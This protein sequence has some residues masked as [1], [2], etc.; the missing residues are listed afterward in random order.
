M[1]TSPPSVSTPVISYE[2]LCSSSYDKMTKNSLT[3]LSTS[4]TS[5]CAT[6]N[7]LSLDTN[8]TFYI[9]SNAFV[10]NEVSN[11]LKHHT[12]FIQHKTVLD[13]LQN[14]CGQV[15]SVYSSSKLTHADI[16][17]QNKCVGKN[18]PVDSNCFES[19][20]SQISNEGISLNCPSIEDLVGS[21]SPSSRSHQNFVGNKKEFDVDF[22]S[23]LVLSPQSMIESILADTVNDSFSQVVPSFSSSSSEKQSY[24][25]SSE[26][27]IVSSNSCDTSQNSLTPSF[28]ENSFF[29]ISSN[30]DP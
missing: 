11:N 29:F 9:P 20:S 21:P 25:L 2:D 18:V 24:R 6:T 8:K 30:F 5:D 17:P 19:L 14:T 26:R 27:N 1:S 22:N 12:N 7:I 23:S 10:D 3:P 13:N 4:S 16:D 15:S 28:S